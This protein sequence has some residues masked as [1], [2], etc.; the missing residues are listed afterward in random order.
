[1]TTPPITVKDRLLV[2][3][4]IASVGIKVITIGQFSATSPLPEVSN[5]FSI[6]RALKIQIGI[7]VSQRITISGIVMERTKINGT[8]RGNQ[9]TSAQ[10][11]IIITIVVVVV[12]F[13]LAPQS[14]LQ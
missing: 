10:P 11:K 3:S 1:M 6:T 14:L 12:I 9:V 2:K 7:Y 13:R 8:M 4:A 5:K